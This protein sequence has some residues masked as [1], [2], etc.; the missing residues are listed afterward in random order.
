MVDDTE[1]KENCFGYTDKDGVIE[2]VKYYK[3]NKMVIIGVDTEGDGEVWHYPE[4]IRKLISALEHMQKYL[5]D[6][7]IV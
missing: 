1:Q 7:G 2:Y 5:V 4:D 6:E 3:A